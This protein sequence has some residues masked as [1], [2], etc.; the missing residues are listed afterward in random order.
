M[1]ST[2]IPNEPPTQSDGVSEGASL[3]PDNFSALPQIDASNKDMPSAVREA[4]DALVEANIPE[5]LFCHGNS[6]A[7]IETDQRGV[8]CITNLNVDGLR[9]ELGRAA[10]YY[11]FQRD[12]TSM[13]DLPPL[14]VVKDILALPS[15]PFPILNR[16]TRIP[17]FASDG[18]LQLQPGYNAA[19]HIY[20]APTDGFVSP[21]VP[22]HP[23]KE[24]VAEARRLILDELLPDF[25]FIG[26]ADRAN[27]A[28]LIIQPAARE[29]ISGPTP[30]YGI[31][32]PAPGTGASL[33]CDVI[34]YTGTGEPPSVMSA[35]PDEA[36]MRRTIFA[37]L[38]GSP[39]IVLID[40]IGK[41]LDS[42][43]L[44]AV[45]T[46][47]IYK[48]RVIATS[49]TK[50]V[51]NRCAWVVTG[52]NIQLSQELTRRTIR[53]RLDAKMQYPWERLEQDFK[54][55]DLHGWVSENRSKLVWAV[56]TL[57]QNW[58]NQGR[59]KFSGPRLGGYYSWSNTLG[60]ILGCAEIKGF[61]G[62]RQNLY[63]QTDFETAH[64]TG[65]TQRWWKQYQDCEV[66]ASKL[67]YLAE[68]EGFD[69]GKNEH[70][71]PTRLGILLRGK[72]GCI[73]DGLQITD[74]TQRKGYTQWKLVR[75][76]Q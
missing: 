61:L 33:L 41:K 1:S 51:P 15:L 44:S 71:K 9:G 74:A 37:A 13:P 36:E 10:N 21:S 18:T 57:I 28:C 35:P 30:I 49:E 58:I 50:Q 63:Q 60:G 6:L 40:N 19:A 47:V 14:W 20:Y 56:L 70:G 2:Q 39:E 8:P 26:D 54:H 72:L 34:S 4:V 32:K 3:N 75:I 48:D 65:F 38:L 11:K 5:R 45:A 16:V 52:N 12:S 42:S 62:N 53:I 76:E 68:E 64:W 23:T 66:T 27:A 17:V 43:A 46:S 7:R 59:P 22:Q 55:P 73:F 24:D 25:P 67:V 31:D 69:L 29:L